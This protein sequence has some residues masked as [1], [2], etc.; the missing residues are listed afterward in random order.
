MVPS[1]GQTVVSVPANA[2]DIFWSMDLPGQTERRKFI[3]NGIDRLISPD[4]RSG[5]IRDLIDSGFP[6]VLVTHWQSLYTQG[7]ELGLEGLAMLAQRIQKVFG[8]DLE[9]IPCSELA[10]R[11]VASPR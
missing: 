3:Q 10:R 7:T 9:W 8:K 11:F 1:R 5:R 2:D 6:A 4:G